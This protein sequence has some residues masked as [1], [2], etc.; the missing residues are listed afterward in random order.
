MSVQISA[1]ICTHN[2]AGYLSKALQSLVN[3]SLLKEQFEI[4]VV[5]NKST[6][7]TQQVVC[8]EF[9]FVPNLRYFYDPIL[10]LSQA[11]NT[12]WRNASGEYIAYLD[13]DAI[14][15]PQWLER[16][17]D[18]FSKAVPQPGGVGGKVEPIW[19]VPRPD[20]LPDPLLS[21]LTIVD[22]SEVPTTLDDWRYIAGANMAFPKFILDTIGGFPMN[23]GRQGNQLLSNEEICMRDQIKSR[24]Y[25]IYY[26]PEIVVKHHVPA[27]RL[28]QDWFIRR[29]YWQGISEAYLLRYQ[30]SPSIFKRLSLGFGK[31]KNILKYPQKLAYI[32]LPSTNSNRLLDKCSI[33]SEIGY[34]FGLLNPG[35]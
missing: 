33:S 34:I 18:A 1:I 35:L 22:W 7:T 10:G 8:E 17:L 32:F 15:C 11:R 31:L 29:L 20:W 23:L 2:R 26:H 9:A 21:Y 30:E 3:Q 6:D 16:I 19:E 28:T 5:D 25:T 12:G 24:G 13:D 14:A 27:S 4:L